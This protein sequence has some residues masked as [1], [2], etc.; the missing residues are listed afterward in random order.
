[1]P[2]R[3]RRSHSARKRSLASSMAPTTR[4]ALDTTG[5]IRVRSRLPV[6]PLFS[7]FA[8]RTDTTAN[9]RIDHKNT[10]PQL[11]P[12][13]T[14]CTSLLLIQNHGWVIF[15]LHVHHGLHVTEVQ[16]RPYDD[17]CLVNSCSCNRLSV[18][19]ESRSLAPSTLLLWTLN[20]SHHTMSLWR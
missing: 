16:R 8:K 1:M 3:R 5:T 17:W 13:K 6:A 20:P 19:A 10:D 2:L 15:E 7:S 14:M 12:T 9:E 11:T 18:R 4:T